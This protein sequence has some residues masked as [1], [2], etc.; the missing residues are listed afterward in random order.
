MGSPRAD[1]CVQFVG[2]GRRKDR[3]PVLAFSGGDR[4]NES[5]RIKGVIHSRVAD[6]QKTNS[7]EVAI[8]IHAKGL[9]DKSDP[10]DKPWEQ[11]IRFPVENP[12][13][14]KTHIPPIASTVL[15]P[16]GMTVQGWSGPLSHLETRAFVSFRNALAIMRTMSAYLQSATPTMSATIPNDLI[17]SHSSNRRPDKIANTSARII[18]SRTI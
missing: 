2:G 15:K 16:L 1:V 4:R 13:Y 10:D 14:G 8:I 12:M 11:W 18:E 9:V 5:K 17:G 3:W 6:Y 7:H